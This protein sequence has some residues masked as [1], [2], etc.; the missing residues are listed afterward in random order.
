MVAVIMI[1][2]HHPHLPEIESYVA[3]RHYGLGDTNL[4]KEFGSGS[5]T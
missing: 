1:P 5:S 4:G 2:R 3:L